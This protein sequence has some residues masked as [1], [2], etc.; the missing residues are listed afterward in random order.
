MKKNIMTS[1]NKHNIIEKYIV[2]F[3]LLFLINFWGCYS[4]EHIRGL[5]IR[6]KLNRDDSRRDLSI[7]TK[8]YKEYHFDSFMYTVVNDSLL[9]TGTVLH[10]NNELP[11]QGKI[12]LYDITDIEFKDTNIIGSIAMVLGLLTVFGIIIIVI[13]INNDINTN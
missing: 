1:I 3:L 5:E 11:F 6:E 4:F 7:V 8:D 13:A 2:Y 10:L 9:G 12:A